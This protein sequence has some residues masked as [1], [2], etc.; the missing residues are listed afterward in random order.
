M[1]VSLFFC[2][3]KAEIIV[4]CFNV[5]NIKII[6]VQLSLWTQKTGA[7]T[8]TVWFS[9]LQRS[10]RQSHNP[11]QLSPADSTGH[12]WVRDGTHP[13]THRSP[14][15]FGHVSP[16]HKPHLSPLPDSTRG[17]LLPHEQIYTLSRN[18][19]LF[20]VITPV[21]SSSEFSHQPTVF[22]L[23]KFLAFFS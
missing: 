18:S 12:T 22:A 17:F 21:P 13:L 5:L 19:P 7:F 4:D 3:Y 2:N 20:A 15:S 11:L 16:S 23:S 6:S 8:L 1:H 14:P 10:N 9:P